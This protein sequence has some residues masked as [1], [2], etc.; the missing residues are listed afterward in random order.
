MRGGGPEHNQL[1]PAEEGAEATPP[2]P[3]QA[4]FGLSK[5]FGS[6]EQKA[7][8]KPVVLKPKL[9]YERNILSKAQLEARAAKEAYEERLAELEAEAGTL[10]AEQVAK[11]RRLI[12]GAQTKKMQGE[13]RS[14]LRKNRRLELSANK[15]KS[16][17]EDLEAEQANF[18]DDKSFWRA[19]RLKHMLPKKE[20]ARLLARKDRWAELAALPI[21]NR[22]QRNKLRKRLQGAGRQVPY[23]GIVKHLSQWLALERSFGHT[24]LPQ[25]VLAEFL[26]Q[27]N[28]SAH[29]D[30]AKAQDK[31]L[32]V[33]QQQKF[34][35][36]AAGKKERSKKL[37]A[38][39]TYRK[40]FSKRLLRWMGAKFTTAELVSTISPTEAEVRCKLT[41]QEFDYTLWLASLSPLEELSAAKVVV[42][43]E[44]FVAERKHLVVGFSDQIPLWAKSTGRKAVF[45]KDEV[46]EPHQVKDFSEVRLAVAE[47][48]RT[49]EPAE[50][51][52]LPIGY[53]TPTKQKALQDGQSPA[54]TL[55]RSDTASSLD[56]TPAVK[57]KLSF[58]TPLQHSESRGSLE[59][60]LEQQLLEEP[61]PAEKMPEQLEPKPSPEQKSP[62]PKPQ[63]KPLP[64]AG[65]LSIQGNSADDRFRITYEA[66][67]LIYGLCNPD[68]P[69]SGDV[70]KG[71]LVVPGQWARLSNISEKGTWIKTETFQV[72]EKTI[73]HSAGTSAGRALEGFR[74]VRASHPDLVSQLEIMSQPASNVDSVI[75]CWCIEAQAAQYPCS[76]WQRDCFSSVFA[77][78]ATKSMA[79]AQQISCLVAAK[80]TSKLQITDSDFA[81]QFKS[82]VRSK[83]VSL[84]QEHQALKTAQKEAWKVGPLEIVR[85]VVHAQWQMSEKN[86][87]D[88]WVLA[89]AVRNGILAYTP[90]TQTGKLAIVTEQHWAKQAG[91]QMGSKRFPPEWLRDR[92]K[93]LEA[94]GKPKKAD[95]SLSRSA[96]AISD[97]VRWDYYSPEEDKEAE[98]DA[99]PDIQDELARLL[100]RKQ[101]RG[102]P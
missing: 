15:K 97:L 44:N 13:H 46:W 53:S 85:S 66:R 32:S 51:L 49:D 14:D 69:P 82:L 99:E 47:A 67:Q 91:F 18:T 19:M 80:C 76:V 54:S 65:S 17:A 59:E 55:A 4:Q 71:L 40:T 62:E 48:M 6:P 45:A 79:L 41:W 73:T 33:L 20:L 95:W 12:Q 23:P 70:G 78:S 27:L 68:E 34:A 58:D 60:C 8:A 31:K 29:K 9:P 30:S 42:D 39:C 100:R 7:A 36:E 88:Q 98:V 52:V 81:K 28:T 64:K 56:T 89:A 84:R 57:R 93:W 86:C 5:F 16:I 26:A 87:E 21:V 102:L 3:K 35:E 92:L 2:K 101:L 37:Q 75:L 61:S 90:N 22:N 10:N 11:R 83:L 25:D 43:P 38:S 94:D 74:K 63:A 50:M 72:G 24:V 1:V 96:S 77:E